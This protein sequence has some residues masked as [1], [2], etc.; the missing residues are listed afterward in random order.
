MAAHTGPT[1]AALVGLGSMEI[2]AQP[3]GF[4]VAMNHGL[5]DFG[6]S[7]SDHRPSTGVALLSSTVAALAVKGRPARGHRSLGEEIMAGQARHL[8]HGVLVDC[9][10]VVAPLAEASFGRH[11]MTA[12]AMALS[13][14]QLGPAQHVSLVPE[15][16]FDLKLA[17]LGR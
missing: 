17:R 14:I 12:I 2:V 4:D 15:G 1:S 7:D 9:F 11:V 10:V 8:G 6:G 13:A 16:L 3:T 5:R